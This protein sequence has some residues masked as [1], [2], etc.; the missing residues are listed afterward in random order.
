MIRKLY[1]SVVVVDDDRMHLEMMEMVLRRIGILDVRGFSD[2]EEAFASAQLKRPDLIISDWNMDPVDG[3]QL[4]KWIR[5]T[6]FTSDVPFIMATANCS[7]S[8]WIKAI[9]AGVT[10][11]LV[12]PL[13]LQ[14]LEDA[15]LGLIDGSDREWSR[16]H[17][18]E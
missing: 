3:L 15:I 4:L 8:Y 6:S 9:E 7:E 11:F 5:E 18:L 2:A 16:V 14:V 12:K 10:E 13:K 1:R 17:S